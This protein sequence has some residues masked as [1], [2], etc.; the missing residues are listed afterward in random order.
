M[1][2]LLI[3]PWITD[4]AAFDL[5]IRPLGLLY[6]GAFLRL[7]GHEIRLLDCLDRYHDGDA[8]PV[9]VE[10]THHTGSFPAEVIPTPH[11]LAHIN[12]RFRRY[13]I[14]PDAFDAAVIDGPRPD[15]VLVTC[16]MTY[17]YPGACA[18]IAR[19]RELLPDV[20]IM[21]GGVYPSLCPDHARAHSGA[22]MVISHCNPNGIVSAVETLAGL[23]GDGPLP[24]ESFSVWPEPA[25]ELYRSLP[26]AT[27]M[28]SRG[29][30]L[31][32][33]VCASHL[34]T[35]TYE[36]RDPADAVQ[37]LL[38]LAERGVR[39]IAFT[40]DALL[41]DPDRHAVPLFEML[42]D[43]GAP[44][45]LHSPNGLHV[46]EITPALARI[47]RRGGLVTVRLSLETADEARAATFSGK[48]N[49]DDFRRA[50][51][52][53]TAAGYTPG[54][55][56]AYILAGLPG[57]EVGEVLD[58]A[59]FAHGCG[60]PVKPALFSPVPGTKSYDN[61]VRSGMIP[62]DAD[63]LMHNNTIRT[64]DWFPGGSDGYQAFRN[65]ISRMNGT[66]PAGT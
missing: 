8:H 14:A 26:A 40:D 33:E 51:T 18:A 50:T 47:M 9:G 28:T 49:R 30:P 3:N 56:G 29:C 20:P 12:R 39:D 2:T 46:R 11:P 16:L 27:I 65:E 36:R 31:R 59:R 60:V 63:P 37:A 45:R 24:G 1:R 43:A 32:C 25:W 6:T 44:V 23:H 13:G 15:V 34:L 5:W 62:V 64:A 61:A 66:L 54:E 58:T 19:I 7:R 21:L 57:Q 10:R 22:D 52:A 53:L 42:A 4:F 48:V 17:W 55:M 38:R 41:I 35:G